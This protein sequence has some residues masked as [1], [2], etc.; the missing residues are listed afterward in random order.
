M[1]SRNNGSVGNG[2]TRQVGVGALM[3]IA[4]QIPDTLRGAR[5][6]KVVRSLFPSIIGLI[7]R[8]R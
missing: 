7:E 4:N 1:V 5:S 6:A 3:D 2:A 8:D